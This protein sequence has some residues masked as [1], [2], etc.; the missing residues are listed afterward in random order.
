MRVLV[1]GLHEQDVLPTVVIEV[2]KT[3]EQVAFVP[4]LSGR[5]GTLE[6]VGVVVDAVEDAG[7][8]VQQK[9]RAVRRVSCP[10]V[11]NLSRIEVNISIVVD[12]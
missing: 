5:A 4:V 8:I 7:A 3:S 1:V 10:F 6:P 2:E 9:L 12:V 11:S